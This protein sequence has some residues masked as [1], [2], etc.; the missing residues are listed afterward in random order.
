M[1]ESERQ[2]QQTNDGGGTAPRTPTAEVEA[3]RRASFLGF[4]AHEMR[5]PLSTALWSAELLARLSQ[6]ER[7]GARGDKLAGM[8]LRSLQRL[9]LLVEDHF[10]AERLDV[11][12]IP[13]HREAVPLGEVMEGIAGKVPAPG[14][15]TSIDGALAVWGD[16][17]LTERVLESL[18]AVVGRG[19]V[20]VRI[21][22][23]RQAAWAE[24]RALGAPPPADALQRPQKGTPSDQTGRALALH[25]A[26]R[27]AKA[28]GGSLSTLPDGYLLSLPIA[29]KAPGTGEP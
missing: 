18:V 22:A 3:E 17:A 14:V 24:I 1:S 27:I 8:C 2:H 25:A 21:V 12:G 9:R 26:S 5:N 16:R 29:P 10:L 11:D 23:V 28:L 20:P 6:S 15:A 7:G 19:G 13:L 4:V